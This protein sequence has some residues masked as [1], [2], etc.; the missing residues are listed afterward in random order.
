MGHFMVKNLL[1]MALMLL[2][3]VL[4]PC[5]NVHRSDTIYIGLYIERS[6][7]FETISLLDLFSCCLF[8]YPR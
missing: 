4:D 8:F 1:Q 7:F 6:L 3:S 2:E 5:S